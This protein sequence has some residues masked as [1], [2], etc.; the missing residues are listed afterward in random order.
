M[1]ILLVGNLGKLEALRITHQD[2]IKELKNE[3]ASFKEKV[4]W[5]ENEREDLKNSSASVNEQQSQSIRSLEKVN[6]LFIT[7]DLKGIQVCI[8]CACDI[9][10]LV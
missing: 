2:M 4:R 6:N 8:S 3:V 5:L 10:L 7:K 1:A 9:Q